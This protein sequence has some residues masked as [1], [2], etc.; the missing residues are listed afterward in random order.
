MK[1]AILSALLAVAPAFCYGQD[2]PKPKPAA[3]QENQQQSQQDSK[4]TLAKDTPAKPE[5]D[6]L[7][8]AAAPNSTKAAV[9]SPVDNKSY[10][11]GAEDVI[12]VHVWDNAQL[13]GPRIVRPDGKLSM[14]LIGEVEASGKSPEELGKEIADAL[15]NGY[16]QNPQVDVSVQEVRSRKYFITGEVQRPGD[17]PLV[18][19]T[20]VLEAISKA[21]GFRDFANTKNIVIIRGQQ[22]FKFNYKEVI[23]GKHLDQNIYLQPGDYIVVK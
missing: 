1:L 6:P 17:N 4:P 20:T 10:I 15:R 23:A 7:K 9:A 18:V 14:P 22:R 8:M 21:G 16:I 3:T 13:T 11:I 12:N 2:D 19:P 5:T